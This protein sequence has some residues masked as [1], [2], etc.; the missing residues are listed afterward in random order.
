MRGEIF[1]FCVWC[2]EWVKFCDFLV[3][4]KDL[5]VDCLVMGYYIWCEVGEGGFEFYCVEDVEKD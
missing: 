5:G 3:M 1:I 4:V 2:N